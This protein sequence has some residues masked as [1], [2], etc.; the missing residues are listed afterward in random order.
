L[1]QTCVVTSCSI[2]TE[3]KGSVKM[4]FFSSLPSHRLFL[5]F[6]F[7]GKLTILKSQSALAVHLQ[8][9]LSS[10]DL[11]ASNCNIYLWRAECSRL[12]LQKSK[13]LVSATGK[14]TR[15]SLHTFL[16][17]HAHCT[18]CTHKS[19]IPLSICCGKISIT[20]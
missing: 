8:I 18:I 10:K 16:H 15:N 5:A 1:R 14:R 3:P 17:L 7:R 12:Y 2:T 13:H 6:I 9:A 20:F 19:V 4:T 11:T